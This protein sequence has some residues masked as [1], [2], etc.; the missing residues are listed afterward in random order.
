MIGVPG[1]AGAHLR[2]ARAGG[3][4]G[5]D[6]LPGLVRALDLLRGARGRSGAAVARAARGVRS[7]EIEAARDRRHRACMTGLATIA[8]VG[9]GMAR[10][11]GIAARIFG[12]VAARGRQRRRH[13]AGLVGAEHLVRRR[14]RRGA[15]ALQARAQRLPARQGPRRQGR[16]PAREST[17]IIL[18]G[19]GQSAASSQPAQARRR[20]TARAPVRIVGLIDQAGWVFDA[21]GLSQRRLGSL[22]LH[23]QRGGALGDVRGGESGA[24]QRE[25]VD[26]MGAHSLMRPVLID[27]A[28]GDTAPALV[29]RARARHGSRAREQEA[30]RG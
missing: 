16:T 15:R 13:R 25:A 6:D 7:T 20:A 24:P 8:V 3:H 22:M 2:R 11:P 19:F 9:L 28:S 1:V 4:L 18:L 30:A 14:R 29:A 23:K 27:V 10:T 17:D 12:A 5:L 21:H 26:A